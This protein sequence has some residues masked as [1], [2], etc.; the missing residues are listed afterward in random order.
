MR[1][2]QNVTHLILSML[3]KLIPSMIVALHLRGLRDLRGNQS[4]HS[5]RK[6][7]P[8]LD[9]FH[10]MTHLFIKEV[11]DVNADGNCGYHCIAALLGMGEESWSLV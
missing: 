6:L 11:I 5:V 10:P 8:M 1:G 7:F 9:Q 4:W 2:Q 3:I